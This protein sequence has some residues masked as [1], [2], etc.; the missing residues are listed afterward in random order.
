MKRSYDDLM[1]KLYVD[2]CKSINDEISTIQIQANHKH[3][4][5]RTKTRNIDIEDIA[6]VLH[7]FKN[8][9]I[10]QFVFWASVPLKERPFRIELFTEAAIIVLSR[11]DE[12]KWKFNTVLD[13]NIHSKHNS[14]TGTFHRRINM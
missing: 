2:T 4:L 11:I 7:K 5:N 9:H 13:P 3:L 10:C 1:V 6:T 12:D 14:K 8:N